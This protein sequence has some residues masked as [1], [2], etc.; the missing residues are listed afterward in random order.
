M[1]YLS[2]WGFD[3]DPVVMAAVIMSIGSLFVKV[4][5]NIKFVII[6]NFQE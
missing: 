5:L 3:L 6:N 2:W 1:G 4:I